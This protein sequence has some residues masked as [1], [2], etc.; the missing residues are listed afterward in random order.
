MKK[1]VQPKRALARK[2]GR[3]LVLSGNISGIIGNVDHII[4]N[5]A[6]VGLMV[7]RLVPIKDRKFRV[8][9]TDGY[10]PLF[11]LVKPVD[12]LWMRN[13]ITRFKMMANLSIAEQ[14]RFQTGVAHQK[15]YGAAIT[16]QVVLIPTGN[17]D[18]P[19]ELVVGFLGN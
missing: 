11:S 10:I 19:Q 2:F 9:G 12:T 6:K 18:F 17:T 8:I 15:L 3:D 5:A 16:I 1:I 4:F 13:L 14:R 7:I